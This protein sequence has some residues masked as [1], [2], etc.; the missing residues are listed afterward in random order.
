MR[1]RLGPILATIAAAADHSCLGP[2]CDNLH[3]QRPTNTRPSLPRG[4]RAACPTPCRLGSSTPCATWPPRPRRPRRRPP[5]DLVASTTRPHRDN[6]TLPRHSRPLG[7]RRDRPR[8]HRVAR[9]LLRRATRPHGP[10]DHACG[11][12]AF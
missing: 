4:N 5:P 8:P 2:S 7:L 9:L 1:A 10:R 6:I 12:A 3:L 11:V